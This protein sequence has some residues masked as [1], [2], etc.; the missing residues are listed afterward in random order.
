ME[1]GFTL[2]SVAIIIGIIIVMILIALYVRRDKTKEVV[3]EEVILEQ[4]IEE[5]EQLPE[6]EEVVVAAVT[7]TAENVQE[8]SLVVKTKNDLA[9]R[10][11]IS[12]QE[13]ELVEM[14]E[15][16]FSDHTLGTSNPGQV[17]PQAS[18]NGYIIVLSFAGKNYRYHTDQTNFLFI[19]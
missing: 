16:V 13:I 6:E 8:H 5:V 10:L 18:T 7:T 17:N 2:K 11:R 15:A 14:K 9:Q 3:P 19:Q 1:K 12:Y 4:E